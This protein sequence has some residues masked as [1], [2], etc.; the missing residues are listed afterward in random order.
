MLPSLLWP[1]LILLAV[2]TLR[3]RKSIIDENS[4]AQHNQGATVEL[5]WAIETNQSVAVNWYCTTD[6][7]VPR[8][9]RLPLTLPLTGHG[10]SPQLLPSLAT[11]EHKYQLLDGPQSGGG[12]NLRLTGLDTDDSGYY[13]AEPVEP[14]R[15]NKHVSVWYKINVLS[16]VGIVVTPKFAIVNNGSQIEL[17][18]RGSGNPSPRLHWL[19]NAQPVSKRYLPEAH[20]TN[21]LSSSRPFFSGRSLTEWT[22]YFTP[23]AS[24]SYAKM[25]FFDYYP[26]LFILVCFALV[27]FCLN[28][29]LNS[30]RTGQN[31]NLNQMR[32]R[33]ESFSLDD[34][35]V[36]QCVAENSYNDLSPGPPGTGPTSSAP[37]S[38]STGPASR[39]RRDLTTRMRSRRAISLFHGFGAALEP[40]S[41][42]SLMD[43]AQDSAL[44]VMGSRFPLYHLAV[45]LWLPLSTLWLRPFAIIGYFS[46][47]FPVLHAKIGHKNS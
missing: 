31:V 26:N 20:Q 37:P 17:E 6:L 23:L 5:P 9:N 46:C 12:G 44:L 35:G 28:L 39:L 45:F 33:I 22:V 14:R 19:R 29:T 7:A 8:Q 4:Y 27:N 11:R 38:S 42:H 25:G 41:G 13:I 30:R 32:L 40:L 24:E 15:D 21:P 36:Y 1:Q 16:P 3:F 10:A 2:R 47:C 34:V 18:C 43:N